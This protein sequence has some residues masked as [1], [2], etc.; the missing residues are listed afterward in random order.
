MK[1]SKDELFDKALEIV[2][3]EGQIN[4][5]NLQ[6][7]LNIGFVRA[8]TLNDEIIGYL[9]L[10]YIDSTALVEMKEILEPGPGALTREPKFTEGIRYHYSNNH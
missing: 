1:E 5:H 8:K 9:I 2:L 10:H 6:R 7:E 3:R 4:C